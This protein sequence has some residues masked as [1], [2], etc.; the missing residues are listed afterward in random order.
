MEAKF[1]N[2]FRHSTSKWWQ[3]TVLLFITLVLCI[4]SYTQSAL[5]KKGDNFFYDFLLQTTATGNISSQVT[6]IDIDET[7]LS[8]VGQW[9][10]PRYLLAKLVKE[11]SANQPAAMG[12]DIL[13]PEPDRSSLKNIQRQFRKDFVLNLGFTGIPPEM[14]D[15]IGRASCRERV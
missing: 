6:I 15:K 4:G 13:F 1:E 14:Q 8:A 12:L 5:F 9:P 2:L 3:F 10:W 7:S 11:L